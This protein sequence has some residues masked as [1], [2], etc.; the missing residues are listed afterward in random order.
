M[1][2]EIIDANNYRYDLGI[3][4]IMPVAGGCFTRKKTQECLAVLP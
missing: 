1:E 4:G 3:M 2:E